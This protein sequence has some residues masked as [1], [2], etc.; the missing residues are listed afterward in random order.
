MSSIKWV[1]KAERWEQQLAHSIRRRSGKETKRLREG[2]W[3]AYKISSVSWLGVSGGGTEDMSI[4]KA[5][6]RFDGDRVR[7]RVQQC[8]LEKVWFDL[9]LWQWSGI[10]AFRAQRAAW[11]NL[12]HLLSHYSGNTSWSTD[13]SGLLR[14]HSHCGGWDDVNDGWSVFFHLQVLFNW[15]CLWPDYQNKIKCKIPGIPNYFILVLN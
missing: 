13:W 7:H 8:F 15:T 10:K 5:K 11:T 4:K 9:S 1:C 14:P 2:H 12:G 3:H 6:V